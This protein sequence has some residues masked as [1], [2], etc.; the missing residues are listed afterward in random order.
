M[1]PNTWSVPCRAVGI[2]P[3]PTLPVELSTI[4]LA[5]PDPPGFPDPITNLFPPIPHALSVEPIYESAPPSDP[6]VSLIV[7]ENREISTPPKC[8]LA[9]DG[10]VTPIPTIPED[11]IRT[12]APTT[13][14]F[15]AFPTRNPISWVLLFGEKFNPSTIP[16]V[17][18]AALVT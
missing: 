11:F 18:V 3:I 7:A 12:V 6:F 17:G 4:I 2:F 16:Y 13:P 1:F 9:E 10:L 15:N 14:P 8:N 5:S